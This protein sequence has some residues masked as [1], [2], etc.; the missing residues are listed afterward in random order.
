MNQKRGF[1]DNCLQIAFS[2]FYGIKLTFER[3]GNDES[4]AHF[5][6]TH[7]PVSVGIE[8]S[9]SSRSIQL[10]V[11]MLPSIILLIV[12]IFGSF[13]SEFHSYKTGLRAPNCFVSHKN[14]QCCVF[15][16]ARWKIFAK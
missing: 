9:K 11:K 6:A 1:A 15:D 13:T 14:I 8:T 10:S 7:N 4:L 2:F 5:D 12:A 3:E 16:R